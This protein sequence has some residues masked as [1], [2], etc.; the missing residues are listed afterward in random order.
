ME[1]LLPTFGVGLLSA[2]LPLVNIEVYLGVVAATGVTDVW[3][4]AAV[5]ALGQMTGKVMFYLLGRTSLE[6]GWVRRR[7]ESARF[8]AS[9]ARWKERVGDRPVLA[10]VV[11]FVSASLGM[12]PL[13]IVSVVAGSLRV[14]FPVFV[15]MGVTG[16][17]LRFASILGAV[18]WFVSH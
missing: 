2:L 17:V 1:W 3:S 12:P 4:L 11:V 8:Q 6:W 14:S 15:V 5:A 16:R 10:G 13:A 9:L 18:S 7:T